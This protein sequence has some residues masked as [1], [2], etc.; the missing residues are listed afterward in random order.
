MEIDI[1]SVGFIFCSLGAAD[2]K[3]K[4]NRNL[5]SM[6]SGLRRKKTDYIWGL[7]RTQTLQSFQ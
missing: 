3:K 4:L 2:K 7:S 6:Q 1:D 5:Y